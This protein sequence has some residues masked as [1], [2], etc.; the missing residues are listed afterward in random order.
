MFRYI[1]LNT[2][3]VIRK[4]QIRTKTYTILYEKVYKILFHTI[5]LLIYAKVCNIFNNF[6]AL[7]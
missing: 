6:V 3:T 5:F 4:H 7:N 1:Q 2:K